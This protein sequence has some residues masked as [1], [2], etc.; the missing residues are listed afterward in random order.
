[1]GV[2]QENYNNYNM[3]PKGLFDRKDSITRHFRLHRGL[4]DAMLT[5]CEADNITVTE[6]INIALAERYQP[7]LIPQIKEWKLKPR[8]K[9]PNRKPR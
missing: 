4:Y 2:K 6:A 5:K 1:M 8:Y 9:Y 7:S 3:P